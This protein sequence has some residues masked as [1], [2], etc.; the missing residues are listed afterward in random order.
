MNRSMHTL[1]VHGGRTDLQRLGVHAPPI[2]LST[3][4]PVPDLDSGT[5]DLD[6]AVAGRI[7]AGSPV[8][9]R[10]HNPTVGRFEAALAALEGA[11]TSVA[12]ASGMAAITA[13]LLARLQHGRHIVAVRPVYGTTEHLLNSHLL[14]LEVSWVTADRIASAMRPDTSLIIIETPGNPTLDI[15]D[16][17]ETVRQ[18]KGVP[19]LVDSTFASPVLQQPL[20][21]GAAFALHSAT[22]FLGGHG[23]V[24]G[25][26]IA[27]SEM[28]A[29]PLRQVRV[30][31]G[32]LMH[33]LAAYLL[34][35]GLATL[36]VRI[37]RAQ[38][39]AGTLARRLAGCQ[40]VS[41]VLYPDLGPD[42]NPKPLH[43]QMR[44]PGAVLAFEVRGGHQAA[45]AVMGSL[46]LITPAV[47]LGST[48]TLIQHPAGLTHRVLDRESLSA[49]GI[50]G[51]LLRL[52][53]GLEDVDD[54]WRDLSRALVGSHARRE[55]SSVCA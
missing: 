2:D 3:T 25:G 42:G 6:A 28:L 22:K 21:H 41:R 35:R 7:P 45:R 44:G 51:G 4:Y 37:E 53:V 46:E 17:E 33:P 36:P 54:L 8:Y 9:A 49:S 40:S 52:S 1:A 31:T 14:P 19:V 32:A 18:A 38:Q 43:R 34:H 13:G 30:A 50:S 47:S 16:I 55:R 10:L 27:T 15:V 48:D 26:V 24:V 29:R 20:R 5:A 12:F 11:E 23:D 39:T